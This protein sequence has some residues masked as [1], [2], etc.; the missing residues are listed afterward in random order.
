MLGNCLLALLLWGVAGTGAAL[1]PCAAV[2]HADCEW[3]A[4]AGLPAVLGISSERDV[5]GAL[6]VTPPAVLGGAE[7]GNSARTGI[8]GPRRSWLLRR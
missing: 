5:G 6:L 3:R 1:P 8:Q 2:A 4:A 7:A